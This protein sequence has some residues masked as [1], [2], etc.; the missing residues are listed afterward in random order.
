[1]NAMGATATPM[2]LTEMY[3]ALQQGIIDGCENPFSTLYDR[4]TQEVCKFLSMTAHQ[5][6]LS[7]FF[8]STEWFDRLHPEAQKALVEAANEAG[9][10][11]SEVLMPTAN[12]AALDAFKKA[13]VT[14]IEDVDIKAFKQATLSVYSNW[15]VDTYN[16]IQEQLAKV[17]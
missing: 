16:L 2:P 6:M 3:P 7:L 10:Y 8:V 1:M 13:G 17:N 14:I 5:K 15:S 9:D 12:N 4:K 11:F